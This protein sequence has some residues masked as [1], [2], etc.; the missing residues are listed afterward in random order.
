MISLVVIGAPIC[1]A[2]ATSVA[3]LIKERTARAFI[4]LLGAACLMMV[5][6]AHVAEVFHLFPSMGWGLPNSAGHYFDLVSAVAGLILLPV[7]Y[8]LRKLAQ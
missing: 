7:G 8:L 1:A 4:Q 5:V 3:V 6:L 2:F